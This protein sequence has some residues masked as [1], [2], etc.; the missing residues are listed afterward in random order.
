M[1]LLLSMAC[2]PPTPLTPD[3][4]SA[5]GYDRLL[6]DTEAL[7]YAP[8]DVSAVTI[9]GVPAF[10]LAETADGQLSVTVQGGPA[11]E[12]AVSLVV[13]GA[14]VDAGALE[15]APPVDPIFDR[16]VA[17]G[18]SVTM[19]FQD[20]SPS[21]RAQLNGPAVHLARAAGAWMPLPL[22]HDNLWDSLDVSS[23]SPAPGCLLGDAGTFTTSA[24]LNAVS[25]MADDEGELDFRRARVSPDLEARNLAIGN[26]RIS[27]I[28]HG[29]PPTD[30]SF[31]LLTYLSFANDSEG[32][33]SD[34]GP[35]QLEQLEAMAPTLVVSTDLYGN[36]ILG[37]ALSA[38]VSF[39]LLTEED[40]FVADLELAL[41]RLAATGAEVFLSNLPR[42]DRLPRIAQAGHDPAELAIVSERGE[43]FNAL[44]D[45]HAGRHDN[46][47]VVDA[48]GFVEE[49]PDGLE[50]DGFRLS[51]STLGGLIS[52]DGVHFTDTANALIAQ[53]I[54]DAITEELGIE[55][56]EVPLATVLAKDPHSPFVLEV[57]DRDPED[58][59]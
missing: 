49:N 24:T 4:L 37:A 33:G 31:A 38:P 34:T 13:D 45:E 46:I 21:Q 57:Y 43:R 15:Y 12:A 3:R 44:L 5:T 28:V 41:E 29:A 16:M 8:A 50:G 18:A 32:L 35:S 55:V 48:Y 39:E 14:A 59:E 22:F 2:A 26:Y 11:G 42:V 25:A 27:Q 30:P 36:D 58:C 19:G 56:P 40:P 9:G 53:L 54:A 20:G 6:I 17:I 23:I 51:L 7:G 52:Y 1:V 47:H 10:G